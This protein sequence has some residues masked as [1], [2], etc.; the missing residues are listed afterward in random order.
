MSDAFT[1]RIFVPEG[2]PDGLRIIDRQSSPG[3]FFVFPRDKWN[4][5]KKRPE[6]R[7]AGIYIL[8]GHIESDEE[9]PE[10]NLPAVYVGQADTISSRI[11][12]HIKGKDFWS[13]AILYV[14]DSGKINATHAKW[15]EYILI[16]MLNE[17]GQSRIQ[18]ANQPLEPTISEAEKAEMNVFL[19]EILQTLPLVDVTAFEKPK[20]YKIAANSTSKVSAEIDTI[21]V[22]AKEEGFN[23]VFLGEDAWYAVRISGG[24]LD[25][26]RYI[27][28]YQVAPISA[29]THIAEVEHI[30]PYGDKGKYKLVFKAPAEELSRPIELDAV[31][32]QPQSARYTNR[33]KMLKARTLSEVFE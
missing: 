8:T 15:L 20:Q 4:D 16:K 27:A 6:L 21:V 25:K 5:I 31:G 30:E 32:S 14:A 24:K 11:D 29:I 3:K 10:D 19:R 22:P 18:N 12:N 26:I 17:A 1:I 23:D 33:E 13:E 9:K 2:D 28:A 7:G